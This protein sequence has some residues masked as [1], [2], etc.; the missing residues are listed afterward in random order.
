MCACV[1]V[2]EFESSS[3]VENSNKMKLWF[4]AKVASNQKTVWLLHLMLLRN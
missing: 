3:G 2:T 4:L 1:C